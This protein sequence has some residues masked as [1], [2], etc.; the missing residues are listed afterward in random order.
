M[1]LMRTTLSVEIWEDEVRTPTVAKICPV[2]A[3]QPEESSHSVLR[4]HANSACKYPG[5]AKLHSLVDSNKVCHGCMSPE[6][7]VT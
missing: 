3:T 4:T 1:T 7:F 6:R 5:N 2:R